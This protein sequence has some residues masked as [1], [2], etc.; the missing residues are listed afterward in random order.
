MRKKRSKGTCTLTRKGLIN[1][2]MIGTMYLKYNT[3]SWIRFVFNEI[4]SSMDQFDTLKLSPRYH[5][6]SPWARLFIVPKH[7]LPGYPQSVLW[8]NQKWCGSQSYDVR[9]DPTFDKPPRGL[10]HLFMANQTG[11]SFIRKNRSVTFGF[12]LFSQPKKMGT[13][14]I[15]LSALINLWTGFAPSHHSRVSFDYERNQKQKI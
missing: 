2:H 7:Q 11:S 13:G 8:K 15:F 6:R 4:L 14:L 1:G 12:C 9:D 5:Q 10:L 3:K